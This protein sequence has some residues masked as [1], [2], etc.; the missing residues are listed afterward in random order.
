MG[1]TGQSSLTLPH[2]AESAAKA[3]GSGLLIQAV[4]YHCPNLRD[5]VETVQHLLNLNG[6]RFGL[7]RPLEPDGICGGKTMDTI[8]DFQRGVLEVP[9]ASGLIRPGDLT[10]Q[11]LCREIP[12]SFGETVLSLTF[13]R[14]GQATIRSLINPI[15]ETMTRYAIDTP[16]RKAHFLAQIGHESGELRFRKEL[17]DGKAYEK[18]EDLG[19]ILEGDGPRFRGRGLIQL[20]GRLNYTRYRDACGID[21]VERPEL[22]AT[23]DRL[24]TDVAGWFWE[25]HGL[26]KYADNDDLEK[27]TRVINGGLN[28]LADRKRLLMR[29]GTLLEV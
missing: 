29:A 28:G 10:L 3:R 4:G 21:V 24:C 11:S 6:H 19:N 15:A 25:R 14:A 16:L 20:T 22:V 2:V 9:E 23:D 17:A 12:V 1:S 26:N 27:I 8:R 7:A 13:L 18:R 5:D